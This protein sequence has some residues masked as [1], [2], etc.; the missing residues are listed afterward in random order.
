MHELRRLGQSEGYAQAVAVRLRQRPRAH[1]EI[2]DVVCEERLEELRP[3][4]ARG[5]AG[6]RVDSA[7]D[8]PGNAH[9]EDQNAKVAFV[10]GNGERPLDLTG[11]PGRGHLEIAALA[12]FD[13][14][15][16]LL[17]H[18][19][20]CRD[21]GAAVRSARQE[22]MV[23]RQHAAVN[24]RT[25]EGWCWRPMRQFARSGPDRSGPYTCEAPWPGVGAGPVPPKR[26]RGERGPDR[27]G[28]YG[29]ISGRASR[30]S[31]S[32]RRGLAGRPSPARRPRGD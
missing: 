28:P 23:A 27:S 11:R 5:D 32:G 15:P 25:R 19:R 17:V 20:R 13:T 24:A 3:E 21:A 9:L 4:L 18:G 10:E 29:T 14:D 16:E 22:A 6:R 30:P 26:R 2:P 7:N 12:G 31:P 1:E 8:A